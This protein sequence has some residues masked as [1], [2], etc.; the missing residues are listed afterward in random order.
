MKQTLFRADF[1]ANFARPSGCPLC[2]KPPAQAVGAIFAFERLIVCIREAF[3]VG[4]DLNFPNDV[5]NG[6]KPGQ[7]PGIDA[8]HE[9]KRREHHKVIPVEDAAGGTAA[10]FHHPHAKRAPEQ[11]T[12][13]IT[14]VKHARK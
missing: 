12:D 1:S 6:C 11:D 9:Q 5:N 7:T 8:R 13:Q 3:G 2:S 14:H 4:V 10:V